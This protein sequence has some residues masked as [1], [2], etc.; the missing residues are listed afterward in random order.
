M[1]GR[2]LIIDN[3]S[4]STP[5]IGELAQQAGWRP[6]IVAAGLAKAA[7]RPADAV[8]LSGTGTPA[9]G[10]GYEAEL[11]LIRTCDV[12]L[13]GICGGMQLIGRAHAVGL[14]QGQA[15][16]GKTLVRLCAGIELFDGLPREV[17]LFQR[18]I[19]R[20]RSRPPGFEVIAS[21]AGC[22]IEGIRHT[23]RPVY[24][25]QAHLEFRPHGRQILRRFLKIARERID[26]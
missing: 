20:L 2:V 15:V 17:E 13:V 3:G 16:I 1:S 10:P 9:F 4:R 25:F 22:P 5:L 12:P 19:Y 23:A 14:D 18:H 11:D 8:I 21:S 7:A 6:A 26:I 24:G